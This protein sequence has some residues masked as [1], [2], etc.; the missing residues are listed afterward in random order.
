MH[1]TST[2]SYVYLELPQGNGFNKLCMR[3]VAEEIQ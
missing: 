3:K 1:E 2:V